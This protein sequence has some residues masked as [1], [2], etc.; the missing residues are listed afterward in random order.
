MICHR[1]RMMDWWHI[2]AELPPPLGKDPDLTQISN[3]WQKDMD[4]CSIFHFLSGSGSRQ[5]GGWEHSC[6]TPTPP[7]RQFCQY[8][9]SLPGS[10]ILS[11]LAIREGENKVTVPAQ[12][13]WKLYFSNESVKVRLLIPGPSRKAAKLFSVNWRWGKYEYVVC[14]K[15]NTPPPKKK[16]NLTGY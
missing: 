7:E 10:L 15:N 13:Q 9:L 8:I 1:V 12:P 6:P 11:V 16:H 5:L 4:G 3:K 2:L 14:K